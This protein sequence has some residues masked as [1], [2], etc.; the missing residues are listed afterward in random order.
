MVPPNASGRWPALPGALRAAALLAVLTA[1][2]TAAAH[3]L[4]DSQQPPSEL[5]YALPTPGSYELPPIAHVGDAQLVAAGGAPAPLLGLAPDQVALISFVYTSCPAGCPAATATLQR[6]DRLVA[7]DPA[8]AGHVRLVTVS[9]DPERD[10]PERM[11][12]L[13]DELRPAGDWRFLTAR[14]RDAIDPVLAAFGQD[15]LPLVDDRGEGVGLFR[16]V[17]KV[18]LVDG[19]GAI[20]NVYSSGLM[21]PELVLVDA[22]TVLL[23]NARV[24]KRP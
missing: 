20:R 1:P 10:T 14:S 24:G 17:L 15:V 4:H 22:R 2:G 16:H 23:E 18:F 9:F 7:R 19:R 8:L 3:E 11:A 6:I 12:K 5:R 21:E 13:R